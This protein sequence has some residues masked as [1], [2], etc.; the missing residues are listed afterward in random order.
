MFNFKTIITNFEFIFFIKPLC[1]FMKKKLFL[2]A[3]LFFIVTAKATTYYIDSVAGLDTNNGTSSTMPW[4]SISMLNNLT[5][6][7]NDMVLLKA[8]SIW[9]G[10]QLKFNGSGQASSPIIIDQY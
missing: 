6:L 4:K 10:E 2:I 3:L 5:L 1:Y 9:N 7:P 8:G